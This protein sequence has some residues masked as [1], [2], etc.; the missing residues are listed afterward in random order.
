MV[1]YKSQG[2][3][4]KQILWNSEKYSKKHETLCRTKPV[5]CFL[6]QKHLKIRYAILCFGRPKGR[7]A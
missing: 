6:T 5:V 7:W 1:R 4:D 2:A 3:V